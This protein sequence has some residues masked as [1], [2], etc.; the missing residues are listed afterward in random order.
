MGK[1]PY[2]NNIFFT[3]MMWN[4]YLENT[5]NFFILRKEKNL[6]KLAHIFSFLTN[7]NST[8]FLQ[9]FK[10]EKIFRLILVGQ[11]FFWLDMFLFAWIKVVNVQSQFSPTPLE[12]LTQFQVWQLGLGVSF[13]IAHKFCAIFCAIFLKLPNSG[14]LPNFGSRQ[15][16]WGVL[17]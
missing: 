15:Q 8:F 13:K 1:I 14:G 7:Q 11:D 12:V 9:N 6:E 3:K 2:V 4:F 10:E 16:I 5:D 17:V